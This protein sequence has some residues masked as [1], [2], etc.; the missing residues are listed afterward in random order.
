MLR[1]TTATDRPPGRP[2]DH[3]RADVRAMCG[4]RLI[5][6]HKINLFDHQKVSLKK[7]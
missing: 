7:D 2:T 5:A 1:R 6:G 3:V 4:R